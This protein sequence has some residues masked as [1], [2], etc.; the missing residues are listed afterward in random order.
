[1]KLPTPLTPQ[2]VSDKWAELC[3]PEGIYDPPPTV[4]WADPNWQDNA[5]CRGKDQSLWL[6]VF[7]DDLGRYVHQSDWVKQARVVCA[8]CP[9]RVECLAT[10][11]DVI[12]MY[13]Y[14]DDPKVSRVSYGIFGGTSA[15]DREKIAKGEPV[16]VCDGC[17]VVT[18]HDAY[19]TPC[20]VQ[21]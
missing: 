7:N 14:S 13:M 2:Q 9:G 16:V 1:M 21:S 5:R 10:E 3:T 12:R 17:G 4:E 8:G 18:V 11:L 15:H 6:G 20:G 19:H